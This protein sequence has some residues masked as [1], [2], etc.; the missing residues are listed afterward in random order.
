MKTK[1]AIKFFQSA[2][3]FYRSIGI[4]APELN[5]NNFFDLKLV[6]LLVTLVLAFISTTSFFLFEAQSITERI[7]TFYA[8]ITTLTCAACL[9]INHSKIGKL[10]QLKQNVEELVQRSKLQIV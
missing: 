6:F 10:L 2:I 4:Y 8:A 9:L 3:S 5:A 7:E 1:K